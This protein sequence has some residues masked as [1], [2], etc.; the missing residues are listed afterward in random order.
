L[1]KNVEH[2]FGVFFI[3]LA[4]I[5][6]LGFQANMQDCRVLMFKSNHIIGPQLFYDF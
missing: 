2:Q 4:I 3:L 1:G 5:F 6:F